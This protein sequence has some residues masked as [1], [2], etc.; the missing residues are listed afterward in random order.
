VWIVDVER[1]PPVY[2]MARF[3]DVPQL[4]DL[5]REC[6]PKYAFSPQLILR[7]LELGLPC[8]VAEDG[9]TGDIAGFAMVMPEVE[10]G[11]GVLITLDVVPERR[12]QGLGRTMVAWCAKALTDHEPSIGAMWLTVASRN[13]G[14]QAFYGALGFRVVDTIEGYY[15]DDDAVVMVKMDLEGLVGDAPMTG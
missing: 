12:R 13:E 9:A 6:F 7:F 15:R 8:V 1:R 2:R 11:T 3:T 5:D 14:A 4:A 10:E